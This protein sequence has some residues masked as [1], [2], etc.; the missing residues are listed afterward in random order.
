MIGSIFGALPAFGGYGRSKINAISAKTTM[1]GAIMG[2]LTL[3]TIQFLLG[4]LYFVPKCMLSVITSVIGILL[5]EEAPYE[6][7]F[8]WRTEGND[9]SIT[10]AITVFTTLFFSI[11]GG[12]AVGLIYSL[13]R[14]IK[15][16]TA[17]RIQILG[18]IPNSNTFVDAD[19]PAEQVDESL[20]RLNVFN[21]M[22]QTLLN[23]GAIEEVEG[24]LIIKIP[25]P[26][27]FTNSSDLVARLKRVEMYGST[28]AHP[29]LKRSR[30]QGMTR[31]VIFDLDSM[32]S[33]DSSAAQTVKNLIINY[34]RRDIRSLF[35]RVSNNV[36]PILK[37]AGIRDLL[38]RDVEDLKYNEIQE[39]ANHS[40]NEIV[41]RCRGLLGNDPYFEHILE[42]LRLIDCFEMI[43]GDV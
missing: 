1:S 42:A 26:L 21:D 6:L 24:C 3:L 19:V 38:N 31:Y 22:R 40:G 12:I 10:F 7:L 8:Y 4:Y 36:K 16:S 25:E 39:L 34:Q 9:E 11:E 13:I 30:D 35:V 27:N 17:S 28:R 15:N 14:V 41:L 18:R 33:I 32:N 2:I 20:S 37:Q 5:I 29:A 43:Y 23:I